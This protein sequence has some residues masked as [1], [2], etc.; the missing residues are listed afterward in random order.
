M[1][2]AWLG[3]GTPINQPITPDLQVL[4]SWGAAASA[5]QYVTIPKEGDQS[6]E[7]LTDVLTLQGLNS[8]TRSTTY[9]TTYREDVQ[10]RGGSCSPG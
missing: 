5:N 4:S 7:N 9:S 6:D 1:N 3:G 2:S 8:G 10:P